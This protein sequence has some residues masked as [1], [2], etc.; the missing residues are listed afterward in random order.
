MLRR[1]TTYI[2]VL[3]VAA[4]L[5]GC[6][7]RSPQTESKIDY[8]TLNYETP[9]FLSY[10]TLPFIIRVDNFQVVPLFDTTLMIYE[11]QRST[12]NAYVDH[13]WRDKPADLVTF[14]LARDIRQSG[15]FKAVFSPGS[16]FGATHII[17]GTV[18]E[19]W[20]K[21]SEKSW[22]AVVAVNI[23]LMKSSA[24]DME[25]KMIFQKGYQLKQ[26]CERKTPHALAKA[27]STAMAELSY[28][29]I[30]DVYRY[31]KVN[32]TRAH[33]FDPVAGS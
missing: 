4:Q 27:M 11:D 19:F 22:Q 6:F 8:Y 17:D 30:S 18:A 10:S 16:R 3:L 21:N 1:Y 29:I 20:E 23:T 24:A 28:K 25:K 31:L 9:D 5:G 7:L 13:K 15:L 32:D 26:F 33:N 14:F 2:I 12:Q